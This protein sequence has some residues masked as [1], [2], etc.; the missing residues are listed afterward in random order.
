MAAIP[1]ANSARAPAAMEA[2]IRQDE[3]TDL[4]RLSTAGSVDDG[5][6]TLIGRLLYDSGG[7]YEDQ[8]AS[9]RR[10][11]GK[12]LGGRSG[13][14]AADRRAARRARTGH[15]HRRGVPL[16]LDAQ[17]EVHRRGHARPR[18]I[19]AQHGHRRL[20]GEP[21]HHPGGRAQRRAGAIAAACVHLP[22]CWASSTSWWR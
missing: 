5:K 3:E 17:A 15:H 18:A 16:F 13:P 22:R 8:L 2:F 12:W 20:H 11:V 9:V 21:G 19:Y 10:P 1:P 7:A 14:G 6:S 4:M